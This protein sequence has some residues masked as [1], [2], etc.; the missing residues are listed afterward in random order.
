MAVSQKCQYAL[1]AVFELSRHYGQGALNVPSIAESQSIPTRFLENILNQLK[2]SGLVL[3]RRGK[4]GGYLLARPPREIS[5]GEIIRLIE[6]PL[7]V[8]ACAGRQESNCPLD[9]GCVFLPM[10]RRAQ[11]ALE[12]VYDGTTLADLLEED[13]RQRNA[14]VP[15]YSI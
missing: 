13:R 1:R 9:G 10:W 11:A 8:V 7:D 4:T 15:M 5:V 14:C 2:Q 6:G 12:E 3:S